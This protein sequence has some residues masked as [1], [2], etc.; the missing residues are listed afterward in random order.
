MQALSKAVLRLLLLLR[1]FRQQL[2]DDL[3]EAGAA[4]QQGELRRV[5]SM[6]P[7]RATHD[8]LRG[9]HEWRQRQTRH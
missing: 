5:R 2:Q 9:G 8:G 4:Q 3:H 1:T 6:L 7:G